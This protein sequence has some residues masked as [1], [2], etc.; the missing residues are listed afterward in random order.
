[1]AA[2]Q[3]LPRRRL[4]QVPNR[5][6]SGVMTSCQVAQRPGRGISPGVHRALQ[7]IKELLGSSRGCSAI[8]VRNVYGH[9]GRVIVYG[10]EKRR[11]RRSSHRCAKET[12]PRLTH[13]IPGAGF[14]L[15][16][17]RYSLD[18]YGSCVTFS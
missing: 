6:S 12:M 9:H 13:G 8:I 14:K 1:M 10:I 16:N 15:A 3:G 4:D 11:G 5:Q 2:L 17:A 18:R 7:C